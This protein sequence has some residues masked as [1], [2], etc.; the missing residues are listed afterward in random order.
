M[1]IP[2]TKNIPSRL[3]AIAFHPRTATQGFTGKSNWSLITKLKQQV[4]V[5]EIGNGDIEKAED[6]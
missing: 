6:A 3:D 2:K 5:P 1:L 4:S